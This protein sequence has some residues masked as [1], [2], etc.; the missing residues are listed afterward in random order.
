MNLKQLWIV[1]GGGFG[2]EVAT[3][4]RDVMRAGGADWRLAGFVDDRSDALQG[5]DPSAEVR[6]P[7]AETV[8]G[9][10]DAFCIAIGDPETR[11]RV[12][13]ALQERGCQLVS[14]IHPTAVI[15]D[16]VQLGQGCILAPYVTIT[17]DVTIGSLA[18][19]GAK[20]GVG[21]DS[22]LG[23]AVTMSAYTEVAGNCVL[24]DRVFLGSHALVAPGV[25]MQNGS[26]A[27]AGAVVVR[28]TA[29]GDHVG[30]NPA[31][32]VRHGADQAV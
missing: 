7:I 31:R 13:D 1:G 9:S 5:F 26:Y 30:G 32:T 11:L 8:P 23:T 6:H 21:H 2:R 29:A 3:Y 20:S 18:V 17:C 28:D 14:V 12:A 22:R 27:F 25:R 24:G 10:G 16:R 15:G 19:L 4:A